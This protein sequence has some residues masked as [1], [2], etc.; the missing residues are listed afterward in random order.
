MANISISSLASGANAAASSTVPRPIVPP[1]ESKPES[2]APAPA[3]KV[4]VDVP[5]Q[6]TSVQP[7]LEQVQQAI[8]RVKQSIKPS[9]GNSLD[10]QVDQSTG[11]TVVRITDLTTNTLVRQIPSEEMLTIARAL[12]AMQGRGG[13]LKGQA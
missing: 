3:A 6:N 7:Q 2:V 12:D 9:L 1:S 10:F 11:K 13:L 8:E 5:Q 4:A